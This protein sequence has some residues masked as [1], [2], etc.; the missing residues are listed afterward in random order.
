MMGRIEKINSKDGSENGQGSVLSNRHK[1]GWENCIQ[2]QWYCFI[3]V[4]APHGRGTNYFIQRHFE[5]NI[6]TNFSSPALLTLYTWP[7]STWRQRGKPQ[8]LLCV[9]SCT[10]RFQPQSVG[11]FRS[12]LLHSQPETGTLLLSGVGHMPGHLAYGNS[13]TSHHHSCSYAG[14]SSFLLLHTL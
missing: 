1:L 2:I 8:H 12:V 11:G 7:C 4:S 3:L 13:V 6:N 9:R 14:C 5:E 10:P